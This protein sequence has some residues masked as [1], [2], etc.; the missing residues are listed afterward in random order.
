MTPTNPAVEDME[1]INQTRAE[2]VDTE[3]IPRTR[4]VVVHMVNSLG[5]DGEDN[6]EDLVVMTPTQ[7]AAVADMVAVTTT[8]RAV[9][10]EMT[11]QTPAA[12]VVL[13]VQRKAEMIHM[14]VGTT[15]TIHMEVVIRA[16]NLEAMEEAVTIKTREV[17]E[18][19]ATIKAREVT[20]ETLVT[21]R[22]VRVDKVVR[23]DSNRKESA[24][25]QTSSRTSSRG[26]TITNCC[27]PKTIV[28]V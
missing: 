14:E 20:A 1:M 3:M 27:A 2:E 10:T 17:M 5:E 9:D 16:I 22:A 18:E 7:L 21:T 12:V 26:T 24:L 13:E 11:R 8:N 19:A 15:P 25:L 28:I 4:L 23:A 6:L